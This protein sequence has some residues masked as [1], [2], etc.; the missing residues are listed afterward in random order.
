MKDTSVH[1][2]LRI[3][4]ALSE[5]IDKQMVILGYVRKTDYVRAA[6][7]EKIERDKYQY[8]SNTDYYVGEVPAKYGER[9]MPFD[10]ELMRALVSN[11][12]IQKVI[13]EIVDKNKKEGK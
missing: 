7:K 8:E 5:E 13:C 3:S 6:I 10:T 1:L 4:G 9:P 11:K 2:T 12:D